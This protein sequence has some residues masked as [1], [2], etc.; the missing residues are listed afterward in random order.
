MLILQRFLKRHAILEN[1][2]LTIAVNL[3]AGFLATGHRDNLVDEIVEHILHGAAFNQ[4]TCIEVNPIRLVTEERAVGADLH[5]WNEGAKGS[6]AS[7][8]EQHY[9]TTS[10][11]QRGR[12]NKIVAGGRKQIQTFHLQTVAIAEHTAHGSTSAL[13][14]ATQRLVLERGNATSLVAG[15]WVFANGFAVREEILL[16]IIHQLNGLVEQFRRLTTVHKDG[17]GAEHLGNFGENARTAL[18]HEEIRELA[19]QRICRNA[20]ETVATAALQSNAELVERTS[21]ALVLTGNLIKLSKYLHTGFHLVALHFSFM[22]S[23]S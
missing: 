5:G 10:R 18:C 2:N 17:F 12:R 23:L 9:L 1:R 7:G 14:G 11:C 20:T 6:A 8:G 19:N 16:E 13:L 22:R 3:V 21:L 15:T 4:L